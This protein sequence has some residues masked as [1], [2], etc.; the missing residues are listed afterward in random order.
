MIRIKK[1]LKEKNLVIT[2]THLFQNQT[3]TFWRLNY[4]VLAKSIAIKNN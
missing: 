3:A 2:E 1:K 4:D